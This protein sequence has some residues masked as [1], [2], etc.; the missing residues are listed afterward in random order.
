MIVHERHHGYDG[1]E[2]QLPFLFRLELKRVLTPRRCIFE[3]PATVV[4]VQQTG[5]NGNVEHRRQVLSQ[6]R[7]GN[8]C[9]PYCN[10]CSTHV[11]QCEGQQLYRKCGHGE[12]HRVAIDV[13]PDSIASCLAHRNRQAL[14]TLDRVK[15]EESIGMQQVRIAAVDGQPMIEQQQQP[16][17]QQMQQTLAPPQPKKGSGKAKKA[18]AVRASTATSEASEGTSAD[19]TAGKRKKKKAN[20]KTAGQNGDNSEAGAGKP[21]VSM[22][23]VLLRDFDRLSMVPERG[24]T[25]A[26]R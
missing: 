25:K 2:F 9:L 7:C 26:E 14:R 15:A 19:G 21:F 8:R 16:L 13:G 17:Q 12:C 24:P 5:A 6:H 1:K 22:V 23:E 3:T 11:L 10:F 4:L 18:A 20:T